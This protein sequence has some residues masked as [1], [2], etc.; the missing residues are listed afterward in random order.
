MLT[1][2]RSGTNIDVVGLR[3]NVWLESETGQVQIVHEG[4]F[5]I[6]A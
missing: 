3:F 6:A 1:N 4:R 5:L 2:R